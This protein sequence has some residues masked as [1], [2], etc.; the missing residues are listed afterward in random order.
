M[1][2]RQT[3]ATAPRGEDTWLLSSGRAQVL[4]GADV[5]DLDT[6]QVATFSG[7]VPHGLSNPYA[8]PA[9]LLAVCSVPYW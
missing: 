3:I 8:E 9:V 6:A 5:Y 1:A 4:Y 7:L 2:G